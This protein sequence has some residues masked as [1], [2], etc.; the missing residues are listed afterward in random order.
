MGCI[1]L[2]PCH[3]WT[4]K[5]TFFGC[6]GLR[7]WLDL[8]LQSVYGVWCSDKKRKVSVRW[9]I[10]GA[11]VSVA[12]HLGG[13][14]VQGYW[15]WQKH[16]CFWL[17]ISALWDAK[18]WSLCRRSFSSFSWGLCATNRWLRKRVTRKGKD[19][20]HCMGISS[21]YGWDRNPRED[22]RRP[23]HRARQL[24][25]CLCIYSPSMYSIF[26]H[27]TITSFPISKHLVYFSAPL[28]C[29]VVKPLLR[30]IS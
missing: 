15:Q 11:I 26:L 3:R 23:L 8:K 27:C 16:V 29:S 28:V 13:T 2:C 19:L 20:Q 21:R 24:Y 6:S 1:P 12:K 14:F 4:R 5:T 7:L 9:C 10:R 17:S 22:Q 18:A 30:G 25:G